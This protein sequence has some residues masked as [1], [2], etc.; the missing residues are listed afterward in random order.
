[1]AEAAAGL[2]HDLKRKSLQIL[3]LWNHWNDRVIGG[4]RVGSDAAENAARVKGGGED[5]VLKQA[6]IYMVGATEGGEGAACLQEL[7]RAQMDF[8]VTTQGVRYRSSVAGEGGW[9]EDDQIPTGD[10]FFVGLGR[11][12]C[13]EPV[14]DVDGLEGAFVGQPIRRSV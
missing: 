10:E 7:E 11:C 6:G 9:V 8:F 2:M 4:L 12:L 3:R 14:E 13:L 1:M 5:G